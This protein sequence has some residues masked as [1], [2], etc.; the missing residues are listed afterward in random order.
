MAIPC[1]PTCKFEKLLIYNSTII[2]NGG[3]LTQYN[4]GYDSKLDFK[5]GDKLPLP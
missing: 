1:R 3:E 2:V 5:T 4:F